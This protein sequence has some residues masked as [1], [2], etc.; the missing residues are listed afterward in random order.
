[1]R[2]GEIWIGSGGGDYTGKPRPLLIV[3]DDRF[4]GLNSVTVCPI[5]SQIIDGLNIRPTL[6]PDA[7]NGLKRI[8]QIMIDKITTIQSSKLQRLVGNINEN[9]LHEVTIIL[10]LYLSLD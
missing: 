1:M 2:R 10:K 4:S 3:R 6:E 5:T 8:S 9:Q 7:Q